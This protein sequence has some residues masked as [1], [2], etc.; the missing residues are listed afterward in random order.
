[1]SRCK[2][3]VRL[4]ESVVILI[5]PSL[6]WEEVFAFYEERLVFCEYE[7]LEIVLCFLEC[8]VSLIVSRVASLSWCS[9]QWGVFCV[10]RCHQYCCLSY[11]RFENHKP[12]LRWSQVFHVDIS[13]KK[14]HGIFLHNIVFWWTGDLLIWFPDSV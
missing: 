12:K 2:G 7:G 5:F 3:E 14:S 1:M 6:Y 8:T 9:K 11:V 10:Y 13:T 4:R